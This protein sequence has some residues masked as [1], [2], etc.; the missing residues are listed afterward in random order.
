MFF[1]I[2]NLKKLWIW[3]ENTENLAIEYGT[4]ESTSASWTYSDKKGCFG[5]HGFLGKLKPSGSQN[6]TQ[7]ALSC[8][9]FVFS[10]LCIKKLI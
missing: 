2:L 1:I 5:W 10:F 3:L 9:F 7:K 8:L 6:T 4:K